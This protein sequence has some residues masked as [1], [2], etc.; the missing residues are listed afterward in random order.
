MLMIKK[1][2]FEC[3]ACKKRFTIKAYLTCHV[4]FVHEGKK[5]FRCDICEEEYKQKKAS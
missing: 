2:E 5:P 1:K 3:K 4:E